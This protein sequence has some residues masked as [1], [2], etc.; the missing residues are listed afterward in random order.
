MP[1]LD[2]WFLMTYWSNNFL[3][4]HCQWW[5]HRGHGAFAPP[6]PFAPK[7]LQMWYN[8]TQFYDFRQK[9]WQNSKFCTLRTHFFFHFLH[10][11]FSLPPNNF[12]SGATTELPLVLKLMAALF[13]I[14]SNC[15]QIKQLPFHVNTGLK[16]D[17]STL[18]DHQLS[19]FPSMWALV[20]KLT[21][22]LPHRL[23]W[24]DRTTP[25]VTQKCWI[26]GWPDLGH[27]DWTPRSLN[28]VNVNLILVMESFYLWPLWCGI[29]TM[30]YDSKYF[31]TR[32]GTSSVENCDPM[33]VTL[34]SVLLF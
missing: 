8:L 18:H 21:A 13:M 5:H 29:F 25:H 34:H 14:I 15:D 24:P 33:T 26:K 19:N 16:V 27:N 20:L 7:I 23:F 4:M 31:S 17:G 30:L 10:T 11:F 1:A 2:G 12:D 32:V 22:A 28:Y 3:S 6:L 9:K